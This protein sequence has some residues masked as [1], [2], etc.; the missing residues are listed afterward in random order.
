M[1]R[2]LLFGVLLFFVTVMLLTRLD[3]LVNKSLYDYGLKYDEGWYIEYSLLYALLYQAVILIL[4][5]YTKSL[6]LVAFTEVFV[7]TSTQD[8]VY[9]GLWQG[10]F[11]S[12]QW[13]WTP[14]FHLFGTWTTTDQLLLS[15]SA[16]AFVSTALALAS[17]KNFAA[18]VKVRQQ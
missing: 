11:P 7:L 6:R 10:G 3:F 5:L 2:R 15:F 17:L 13:A 8:L 14:F 4:A 18:H 1:K 9:F 16:N 12:I